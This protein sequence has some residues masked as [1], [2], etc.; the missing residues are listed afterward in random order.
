LFGIYGF[1]QL[2]ASF[3]GAALYTSVIWAWVIVGICMMTRFT[4]PLTVF[5]F[6]GA[7][8]VWGWAWYWALLFVLPGLAFAV[9]ALLAQMVGIA[10]GALRG[11]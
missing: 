9:P 5:G 1:I 2:W 8:N 6:L 7:M 11:R 3:D 4:L 10:T